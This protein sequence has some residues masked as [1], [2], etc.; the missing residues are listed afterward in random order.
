MRRATEQIRF[1][2]PFRVKQLPKQISRLTGR[3]ALPGEFLVRQFSGSNAQRS[4]RRSSFSEIS[5]GK[6]SKA[7]IIW[8][9][10]SSRRNVEIKIMRK[11]IL[12]FFGLTVRQVFAVYFAVCF[13]FASASFATSR[14]NILLILSDD[15]GFS[16]LGCYGGEIQTPNLDSLAKNGIR[17]TNFIIRPAV[18]R[19][20]HRYSRDFIH[21]KL[22][23]AT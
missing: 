7:W 12:N 11:I 6:R 21:I 5:F 8:S 2:T 10:V 14:P 17:F 19:P 18:V 22:A 3:R 1:L 13:C 9:P 16:D 15:M 4:V 23:W 20:E